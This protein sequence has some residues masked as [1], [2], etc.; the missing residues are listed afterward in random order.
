MS[1]ETLFDVFIVVAALGLI[2]VL[3]YIALLLRAIS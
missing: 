1:I 2:V 3:I